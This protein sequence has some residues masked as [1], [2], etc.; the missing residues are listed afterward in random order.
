MVK[1]RP[2]YYGA[3][4]APV[5][6]SG[7]LVDRVVERIEE[8][9]AHDQL[10]AGSRLP[11][12]RELAQMLGVSRPALREAVKILAARGWLVVRHGQGVF[13]A[14][15]AEG[16]MRARLSSLEVSLQDLFAMREVLEVAAA[17]WAAER[18]T[19]LEILELA[20]ALERIE[21]ARK[22][23]VDFDNLAKLDADFH[24]RIV[25]VAKNSFLSQ[26][27]GVL[28]EILSRGMES[29]LQIPRRFQVS[30]A[31]HREIYAAISQR[32]SEAAKAAA[33]R[34]VNGARAGALRR[35]RE[36]S[37]LKDGR[38][39]PQATEGTT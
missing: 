9:L 17:G 35:L 21:Q 32:D 28:Q 12:E 36:D 24:L 4:W 26:T 23:P 30:Q 1:A 5:K 20:E 33:L 31:E 15:S 10:S 34:H 14:Q 7:T 8:L 22:K 2:D 27:V 38:A 3:L 25:E 18:T 37:K 16:A 29:T 19:D 39:R 13:V 6:A 11:P